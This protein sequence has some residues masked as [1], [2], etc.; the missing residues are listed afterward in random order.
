MVRGFY[1]LDIG[2]APFTKFHLASLPAA[3][4][5]EARRCG[6]RKVLL[7]G[8][9]AMAASGGCAGHRAAQAPG[10]A[11][12]E[13]VVA[14]A[15]AAEAAPVAAPVA[16]TRDVFAA[17]VAPLLARRCAPCHIPGGK[18]YE[19]LPF[20]DPATVAGHPEGIL[21]RIKDPDEHALIER[22]IAEQSKS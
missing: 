9:L 11:V 19:R 20:D 3:P 12:A 10:G 5:I 21:K 8:V 6:M 22:W 14:P 2:C 15:P 18:M 13:P 4:T 16:A 17:E 7:V 1:S